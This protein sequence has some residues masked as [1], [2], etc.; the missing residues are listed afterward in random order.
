MRFRDF[1]E[2]THHFTT[3]SFCEHF[4]DLQLQISTL[5]VLVLGVISLVC[6]TC[7]EKGLVCKSDLPFPRSSNLQ[8]GNSEMTEFFFTELANV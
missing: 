4:S 5:V 8:E 6:I 3:R 2:S 1:N 7:T